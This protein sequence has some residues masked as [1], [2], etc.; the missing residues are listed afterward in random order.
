VGIVVFFAILALVLY[1][2]CV[3]KPKKRRKNSLRLADPLF[4]RS[5]G[6]YSGSASDKIHSSSSKTSSNPGS[7]NSFVPTALADYTVDKSVEFSYEELANATNGFSVA[8]KIGEGGFAVVFYGEIRGQK[9]AIKRMNLQATKEFMA[10]LQVLTHVHHTNLVQLIGYCTTDFL[11]LVYEFVENGTLDQH[12]HSAKASR[13][14]L[15]WPSRVQIA[16]DA[17]RGLEYIHE[18]TKPTY[19]HRDIKSA[20]ILLDKECHAKVADFGLTKLTE[21]KVG[22]AVTQPTRVVGTWGYMSPEYA[23]FG[24]VSP[25]VDVYSFGVVLFEILSGREAIMRGAL[26]FTEEINSSTSRPKE[27]QRALVSFFDPVLKAP[28]GREKLPRFMDPKMRD[29]Y[30]LDA[31]W[32]MAQLAGACTQEL[33]GKRPTMRKAVVALMTLSS[34]TQ[35]YELSASARDSGEGDL[36]RV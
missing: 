33:P 20:N 13:A 36:R 6:N 32:K 21:A 22:N 8:N 35:D 27:E 12:L 26:T 18:H 17:A 15:S 2:L 31:A 4:L 28:N 23:R 29:D 14:A 10:E 25:M 34:T 24:D 16:L 19:I 5:H 11:F 9:L 3:Y 30:P 7:A 1:Y